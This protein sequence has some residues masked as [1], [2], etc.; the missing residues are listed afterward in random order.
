LQFPYQRQHQSLHTIGAHHL[1]PR[2]L[3][4][5][6]LCAAAAYVVIVRDGRLHCMNLV[7]EA[8]AAFSDAKNSLKSA[9]RQMV[10]NNIKEQWQGSK[11]DGCVLDRDFTCQVVVIPRNKQA[12]AFP[13]LVASFP[14]AVPAFSTPDT[15]ALAA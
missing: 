4:L 2:S 6:L 7:N 9:N 5:P 8:N 11:G 13:T 10:L 12:T 1:A 3:W 15:V 14:T